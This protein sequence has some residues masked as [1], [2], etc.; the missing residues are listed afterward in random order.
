MD[1][2]RMMKRRIMKKIGENIVFFILV[3][4]IL[5]VRIILLGTEEGIPLSSLLPK[6]DTW[7]FS[8]E[9]QNYIPGNLFEYINGAAEIY[10]AYD[11]KELIVGQYET[12]KASDEASLNVEIYDMGNEKN[13]FGIYSAERFSESHFIPV[14]NQGYLEEGTLNFVVGRYYIKLLCFDCGEKSDDVLKSFSDRI[15]EGVKDKGQF[16]STLHHF[17]KEGLVQNSEKYIL[18]NFL[19][20][21]FLHDGYVANYQLKDLDFDCFIIEGKSE[22]DAQ[23]MLKQYLEKKSNADIKETSM[24]Y[25][26]KDRYYHNIFLVRKDNYICGVMKIK[27]D[28]QDLGVRY[29][30]MMLE[31]L[32]K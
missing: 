1:G 14:G 9:P 6:V 28:F 26:L 4:S 30:R 12:E 18:R 11:F 10:L 27:D 24:G 32:E 22:D 15:V 8:E 17:P 19:G 5:N 13:S 21:S 31:S 29:L 25:L 16:P 20:Y 3:L 23:K 2:V 7:K